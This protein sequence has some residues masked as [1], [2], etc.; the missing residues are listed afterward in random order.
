MKKEFLDYLYELRGKIQLD[1]D[2]LVQ[3]AK[4][5]ISIEQ[6]HCDSDAELRTRRSQIGSVNE[7][8]EKYLQFHKY[9]KN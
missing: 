5:P 4:E 1:I 3:I 7:T 2:R 9:D 8:I 6:K